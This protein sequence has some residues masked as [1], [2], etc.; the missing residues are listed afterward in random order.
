MKNKKQVIIY[1]LYEVYKDRLNM[2]WTNATIIGVYKDKKDA[3]IERK[4]QL[5][6]TI[7]CF[8][9]DE[10]SIVDGEWSFKTVNKEYKYLRY[11]EIGDDEINLLDYDGTEQFFQIDEQILK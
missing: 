4:K 10:Y 2:D 5:F 1:V 11:D 7:K 6:D 8:I 3:I 9:K